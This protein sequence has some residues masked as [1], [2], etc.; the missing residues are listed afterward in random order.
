MPRPKIHAS[1]AEKHVQYRRR[2]AEQRQSLEA[3]RQKVQEL[4]NA[5]RFPDGEQ[6][7]KMQETTWY[8]VTIKAARPNRQPTELR[9][10][11]SAQEL[12]YL[13]MDIENFV[14]SADAAQNGTYAYANDGKDSGI[15]G[16]ITLAFL[17]LSIVETQVLPNFTPP[18]QY[19]ISQS[20]VDLIR[21]DN[22]LKPL[23]HP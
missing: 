3:L 18:S 7:N 4:K 9:Y 11:M 14:G 13:R 2:R 5:H 16:T 17:G 1:N 23:N 8:A 20:S 22:K 21:T 10:A 19:V 12:N 6:K 15:P